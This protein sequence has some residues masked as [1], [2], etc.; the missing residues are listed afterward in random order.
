MINNIVFLDID[1]VLNSE[2]FY[3]K[4]SRN[5]KDLKMINTSILKEDNKTV[6]RLLSSIDLNAVD[7][8]KIL[9]EETNAKIVII[10][11]LKVLDCFDKFC[12]YLIDIGLP[13]I[14]K[15]YNNNDNRGKGIKE[16]LYTHD[17]SNYIILD[18]EISKDYD[19]EL[20]SHLIKTDFSDGLLE[21]NAQEAINLLCKKKTSIR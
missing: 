21:E 1:G 15:T 10:S 12:N 14:D 6:L 20:L 4:R 7:R 8:V 13:I 9:I 11:S 17:V 19:E 3:I 5:M 18:D 2:C 16:Y